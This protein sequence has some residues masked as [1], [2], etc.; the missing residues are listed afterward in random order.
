MK[1][2]RYL[3]PTEIVFG[4]GSFRSLGRLCSDF[5]KKAIIVTG[6]NSA[7]KIGAIDIALEQLP[8]AIV[9][10][11]VQEN[12]DSDTC[13]KG[14][15]VCRQNGCDFVVAIGGGS[16]MDAAKAIA[17][18][19]LNEGHCVDFFGSGK[20]ING[21]LPV[22]AVP[23][24]AGTG[25]EVTQYAVIINTAENMKRTVSGPE[26]FPAVAILDPE[27]S[28]TMSPSI[29]ANTGLD[30][31]SQAMEGLVS[32]KS[33]PV[34]DT[35][36]I[37]SCKIVGEWL[38][39]AVLDGQDIEARSRMLYAACLS[40]YVIAQTGTTLVH[41]MGYYLTIE[42]G[43]AHGLANGLLLPP[44]FRHNAE[45]MPGKVAAIATALGYP[46]EATPEDSGDKVVEAIYNLFDKI[47]VSTSAKDSGS[48]IER[49]DWCAEHISKDPTRFKNQPGDVP[50][51]KVRQFY[52][53]AHN[54]R[55]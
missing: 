20:L 1:N 5:G 35:L 7:R 37:E 45:Q 29:T 19:A 46:A 43:I 53:T 50:L 42:F 16:P 3:A 25:S 26:I 38:P 10:D 11:Q 31:L 24:T 27:L 8:D 23:T 34:S 33:T 30:A 21:A 2:F 52:H 36:A 51:E 15:D 32:N 47:G 13:D 39:K 49:I 6:R 14:A 41:G 18:L 40:G 28:V 4:S 9:F 44:I 54:G 48:D 22:V 17:G 55:S 12:P